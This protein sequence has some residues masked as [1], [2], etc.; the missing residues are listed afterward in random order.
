M[1]AF[2]PAL[3]RKAELVQERSPAPGDA[4][5]RLARKD[6]LTYALT[7]SEPCKGTSPRPHPFRLP[8]LTRPTRSTGYSD[9]IGISEMA[10]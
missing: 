5:Y 3:P 1:Q 7:A 2:Y 4:A 8:S 9:D 6:E 10:F